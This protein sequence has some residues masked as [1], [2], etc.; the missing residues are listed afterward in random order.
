MHSLPEDAGLCGEAPAGPAAQSAPGAHVVGDQVGFRLADPAEALG[1]VHLWNDLNLR[2][3]TFARIEGGDG[4]TGGETSWVL[5]L[6][7]PPVDRIEYMY[8]VRES[9]D[10]EYAHH[11]LDPANPL[12][13]GG[14]FGDH[15]WLPMPEYREPT[16]LSLPPAPGQARPAT[17]LDT[18]V[19][20][21]EVLLW[22][23]DGLAGRD[24]PLLLAHDG[25]EMA[26]LAGLTHYVGAMIATGQLP[27][28]RLGLLVP[29]A[30]D[31]RYAVNE[32]YARALA[33]HVVPQLRDQAPSTAPV[34]LM[35]ASL[36]ALAALH[37][38]WRYPDVFAALHL[39]SG[40]FFTPTLDSQ[41]RG[42][43]RWDQVTDFVAEVGSSEPAVHPA[44]LMPA[45]AM[46]CGT[47]E[48]NLTNNVHMRD[49]LR[50]QGFRVS[51]GTVR[52][53]HCYT[54]WRDLF[55]PHLTELLASLWAQPAD[56]TP[57]VPK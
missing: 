15:S 8:A 22:E 41:E 40:S 57:S 44:A 33:L 30:R 56:S 39:A 28:L 37:A 4:G 6:P 1:S 23:P 21:V 11:L 24:A 12:R 17:V 13:V 9:A 36:G 35:G 52:D 32:H 19:G 27:P 14:A 16:W 7:R 49:V 43:S 34:A 50:G 54:C 10:D 46:V 26:S 47:A 3:T 38:H 25:P 2:D 53:T 42:Y 55:D 5:E 45:I 20:D 18:P 48:E 51:W 31:E 29:G